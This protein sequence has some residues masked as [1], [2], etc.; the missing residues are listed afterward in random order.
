MQFRAEGLNVTN[1]PQ[2]QN[3]NSTV[4]NPSNFMG[5]HCG[6]PNAADHPAWI[7]PGFLVARSGG[8]LVLW[9]RLFL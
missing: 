6:E 5:D 4:T 2:L 1:T 9:A 8:E 7:A 3:P